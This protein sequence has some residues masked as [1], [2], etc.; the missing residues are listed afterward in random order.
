MHIWLHR[1][2]LYIIWYIKQRQ[3]HNCL[4]NYQYNMFN[5]I[6]LFI[7]AQTWNSTMNVQKLKNCS[8]PPE[9]N[10][11][12]FLKTCYMFLHF[13]LGLELI[14][15]YNCSY[16]SYIFLFIANLYR[17]LCFFHTILGFFFLLFL[18]SF[19]S[20]VIYYG[21]YILWKLDQ[22]KCM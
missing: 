18:P 8:W 13:L 9:R 22:V 16:L 4:L 1:L 2:W 15:L 21:H 5:V 10:D 19:L 20:Y 17:S 11:I 14:V 3:L 7:W 12:Q 6:E